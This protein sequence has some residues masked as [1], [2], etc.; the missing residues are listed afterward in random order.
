MYIFKK[1]QKNK[2]TVNNYSKL[3]CSKTT[4]ARWWGQIAANIITCIY[5]KCYRHC[6]MCTYKIN[7][8]AIMGCKCKRNDQVIYVD[9]LNLF[10]PAFGRN[11]NHHCFHKSVRGFACAFAIIHTQLWKVETIFWV[12]T[13]G[14]K[15]R[16]YAV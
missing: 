9:W 8:T 2:W 5:K 16:I 15:W 14:R 11:I 10:I 13:V 4:C 7:S 6:D 3:N 12:L 1:I